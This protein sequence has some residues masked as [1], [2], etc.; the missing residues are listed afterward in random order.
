MTWKD[1]GFGDNMTNQIKMSEKDQDYDLPGKRLEQRTV[2]IVLPL[3]TTAQRD[4]MVR[5]PQG[6]L[7]Y[8]ITTNKL[9]FYT[10]VGWE[11]IT[12]L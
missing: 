6:M 12:S 3:K 4:A 5:P 10:G 9:N 7:I 8:N 2:P 11:A 1:H